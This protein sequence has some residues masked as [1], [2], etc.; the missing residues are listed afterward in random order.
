[1]VILGDDF[2]CHGA[3]LLLQRRIHRT[4][5]KCQ[6]SITDG[7]AAVVIVSESHVLK[8]VF[9]R[10]V[11]LRRVELR[12][13]GTEVKAVRGFRM[14]EDSHGSWF[15][16]GCG[17]FFDVRCLTAEKTFF[18]FPAC[19]RVVRVCQGAEEAYPF[20]IGKIW[21]WCFWCWRIKVPGI[22]DQTCDLVCIREISAASRNEYRLYVGYIRCTV[23]D[24]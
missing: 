14:I 8:M 11:F 15:C 20:F 23:I 17:G 21:I 9:D 10:A 3:D 12:Q 18:R 4:D 2:N 6:Y 22:A 7:R 24:F 13:K 5:R 19:K 16:I 1:M